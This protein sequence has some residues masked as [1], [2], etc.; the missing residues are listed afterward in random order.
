VEAG[1]SLAFSGMDTRARTV[2]R[3]MPGTCAWLFQHPEYEAWSQRRTVASDHG[4]LIL[5]GQPGSGKSTL[6]KEALRRHVTASENGTSLVGSFF[7]NGRGSE[8]ERTLQG[9]LRS[10]LFQLLPMLPRSLSAFVAAHAVKQ[11]SAS[12]TVQWQSDELRDTLQRVLSEPQ[13]HPITIFVDA[14]DESEEPR[15][16]LNLLRELTTLAYTSGNEVRCLVS[17]R[18]YPMI[19]VSNCPEIEVNRFNNQDI[20]TYVQQKLALATQSSSSHAAQWSALGGMIIQRASG[21]FLWAVLVIEMLLRDHDDG[22]PLRTLEKRLRTVPP[23]LEGLFGQLFEDLNE[24]E[25]ERAVQ[26]FQWATFAMRHPTME[27]WIQILALILAPD[28]SSFQEW[29]ECDEYIADNEQLARKIRLLSRGLLEVRLPV[30]PA[31]FSMDAAEIGSVT[32]ATNRLESIK[33]G[34]GSLDV[35]NGQPVIQFIHESVREFFQSGDGFNR[36]APSSDGGFENGHISIMRW[37]VHY[38]MLD[39][40]CDIIDMRSG[41]TSHASSIS[42]GYWSKYKSVVQEHLLVSL[43]RTPI[44]ETTLPERKRRAKPRRVSSVGSMGSSASRFAPVPSFPGSAPS[45]EAQNFERGLKANDPEPSFA[46]QRFLE[47]KETAMAA[48]IES[49]PS[50]V[51]R[52]VASAPATP[53]AS[54]DSPPSSPGTGIPDYPECLG[55]VLDMF[56]HH[57]ILADRQKADPAALIKHLR[58]SEGWKRFCCL[59]ETLSSSTTLMYF[60]AEHNLTTWT[61]TLC[62][63]EGPGAATNVCGGRFCYPLITAANACHSGSLIALLKA[64]ADP[65]CRDR[66]ARTALHHIC[67]TSNMELFHAFWDNKGEQPPDIHLLDAEDIF[68]QAPLH[69]AVWHS[70]ADMVTALLSKGALVNQRDQRYDTPLHFACSRPTIDPAIVNALNVDGLENGRL[71]FDHKTAADLFRD[72]TDIPLDVRMRVSRKT[73]GS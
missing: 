34:A 13:S 73:I 12:D 18:Y 45:E 64:G 27:E 33:G 7:F 60:A 10:L 22:K 39:D 41:T 44:L 43:S 71:N 16:I 14:L 32:S 68:K 36:L 61:G 63:V 15:N 24:R 50:R 17:N 25:R 57:A 51:E 48:D 49:A 26:V 69:Y 56:A 19:T 58:D 35:E 62:S 37:C 29:E 2:D 46:L 11:L 53:A 66:K 42:S 52:P 8:L 55:Y 21:I 59:N 38:L 23:A 3:P 54:A 5:K 40:V 70:T 1:K 9:L 65:M 6:M 20:A 47:H 28:I 72:R 31:S 67:A 4:L 30:A